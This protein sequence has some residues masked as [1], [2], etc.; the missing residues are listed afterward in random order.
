MLILVLVVGLLVL[1]NMQKHATYMLLVPLYTQFY[2]EVSCVPA[3]LM[4]TVT[5]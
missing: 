1:T 3:L 2:L 5:E 4:L